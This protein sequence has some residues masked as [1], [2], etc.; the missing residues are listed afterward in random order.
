MDDF[1]EIRPYHDDEVVPVLA[2][3]LGVAELLNVVANLRIPKLNRYLPWLVR[4]LVA[5]YLRREL[6]GVADVA[7]FQRVI[8]QYMDTMIEDHTCSFNVSG[9]DALAPNSAYL[10]ISNHRDIALDPAFVNYALYHHERDTV[11]IAIGDNL[12]SKP[13]AA[14]LMRLNKSFIVRRSAK[15][16]RQMLAAFR[17]LASYI[18]FSLLEERS[19]IWIAQREGRAKDGNDATEAAVIKMIGMAQQKPEES[20][21]DYINKLN[22]VPVS[23][24][25]EW[26]PLD[27]AK[28]QELVHVERDGAY[29]KAEH[30]DLKSIAI[31]VLGNKGDVHVSFGA[32]L[33]G[34]FADAARVAAVLDEAIIDQYRLH[35][36][37]V[38]AYMRIY[39]DESW[40][41]L[42]VPQITDRDVADFEQR[43]AKIPEAFRLK[44]M[45]I[46]ANPVCNQ[47]RSRDL[48]A[49]E[50]AV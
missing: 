10:F 13:F 27:A 36:S 2:K 47:L 4:P 28:A 19:S 37:N 17:Q 34:E 25:Y 8:K 14:D 32:P 41:E 49:I 20:F 31:G 18:R 1:A 48:R 15:G 9:L 39:N 6:N 40:R 7:G 3:L 33:K 12:L 26:D 21:S 43:F 35:A 38:L 22:I 50:K 24:S 44:A 45:E 5:W 42:R 29:L 11:R 16:P 46:Y 30:E 23:I